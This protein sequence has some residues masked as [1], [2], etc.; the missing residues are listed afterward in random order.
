M[1]T[2]C[3][4]VPCSMSGGVFPIDLSIAACSSVTCGSWSSLP[5]SVPGA[6]GV[7]AGFFVEASSLASRC[8]M[9]EGEGENRF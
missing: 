8:W 4:G 1:Y 5:T 9:A 6:T 3:T 2:S 7:T